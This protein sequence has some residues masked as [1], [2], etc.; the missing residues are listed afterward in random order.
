MSTTE[1]LM[2]LS[3]L[4]GPIV[5]VQITR[6]L[7]DKN[8]ERGRKL[9]IFKTLMATRA[10]NLSSAHVEALNSIDLEF[11]S[12]YKNEKLV[13]DC[14]Q[15]YLDHL[16]SNQINID[17]ASW[18]QRRVDLLVELLYAMGKNFGYEFNKTQVK[19]ATYSPTAHGQ[20]EVEQAKLRTNLLEVLEGKR[21]LR[22]RVTSFPPQL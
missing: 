1:W 17:V 15:E 4:L 9:K 12:K 3:T 2:I 20:Y 16:G 14:W 21:D 6:Y 13:L 5:A 10:Y 8:E 7:D 11:S 22:M 19:N 18:D